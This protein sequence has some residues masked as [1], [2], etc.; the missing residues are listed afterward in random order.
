MRLST[1][2]LMYLGRQFLVG[3]GVTLSVLL[4]LVVLFDFV[5]LLRRGSGRETATLGVLLQMALLKM[6]FMAQKVLPFATLF[7]GMLTFLR[8]TRTQEL[9]VARA[10]GVSVWQF[11]MPALLIA[12]LLGVFVATVFNPLASIT[13]SRFEQLESKHLRGRPSLLAVSASGIWLRQADGDD[14]QSV[15]HAQRVSR[16]GKVLENVIVFLYR[17]ADRFV[18]RIDARRAQLGGGAWRF[19]DVMLTSAQGLAEFRAHYSLPTTL[20]VTQIQDSFASPETMSF[21]ALPKFVKMLEGAGFTALKHRLYWHSVLAGPLLL[22]AMVLVAAAFSL[23]LTRH[24]GPGLLVIGCV[25]AGFLLYFLSDVAFAVG[26]SGGIPVV[27]AAWA[28]AGVSTLLGLATLFHL[29]DG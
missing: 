3:I 20:T 9:V 5:E 4:T 22:A 2:L 1:T 11:L 25:L 29:E 21:W 19:E 14:G 15:I 10:A 17:G 23:R 12:V 18:R 28:P 6:P 16:E 8:L 27:L 26:L 24:R 13:M 7:G